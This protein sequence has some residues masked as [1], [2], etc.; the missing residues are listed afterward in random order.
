M[1][2]NFDLQRSIIEEDIMN[3]VKKNE[4]NVCA[5]YLISSDLDINVTLCMHRVINAAYQETKV[6]TLKLLVST[7]LPPPVRKCPRLPEKREKPQ[8]LER[9]GFSFENNQSLLN[10]S[11]FSDV[12]IIGMNYEN[13]EIENLYAHSIILSCS[14]SKVLENLFTKLKYLAA[15]DKIEEIPELY[16]E[17]STLFKTIL[18]E[19]K[20][21]KLELVESI[22]TQEFITILELTYCGK[23][24]NLEK[25]FLKGRIDEL[26]L[27]FDAPSLKNFYDKCDLFNE[28]SEN[29]MQDFYSKL[30]TN[31]FGKKEYADVQFKIGDNYRY[32]NKCFLFVC[33]DVFKVMFT[34]GFIESSSSMT[35]INL[36]EGQELTNSIEDQIKGCEAFLQHVYHR[37]PVFDSNSVCTILAIAHLYNMNHLET[38]CEVFISK[39]INEENAKN[40]SEEI[41]TLYLFSKLY[42][43]KQL[44]KLCLYYMTNNYANY[45]PLI[46]NSL[47]EEDLIEI[48]TN[49]WPPSYYYTELEKYEKEKANYE[50]Y[51]KHLQHFT[52]FKRVQSLLS[53]STNN[54]ILQ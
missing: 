15:N 38:Q 29:I 14:C 49:V 37:Q 35:E 32:A 6:S 24:I 54:C 2:E 28:G 36:F 7:C 10:N 12:H 1:N 25:K 27:L 41:V 45:L 17:Y 13:N 31:F 42:N 39:S 51:K 5:S 33:S 52:N 44:R 30:N 9:I 23:T 50:S 47:E 43:A 48:K 21:F 3:V 40:G 4:D 26:S 46:Q 53:S 20:I 22:S 8:P 18:Y 34:D 16:S 11:A 19:E